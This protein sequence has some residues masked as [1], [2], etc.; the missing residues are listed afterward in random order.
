MRPACV[1]IL[2][3][4]V[5]SIASEPSP[6]LSEAVREAVAARRLRDSIL[7]GRETV[8]SP[9]RVSERD[10]GVLIGLEVGLG[11]N[12]H[13]E[14]VRCLR[15]IYRAGDRH[16]MGPPV[17]DFVAPEVTRTI[18]A[19]ARD[20]YVV[21]GVLVSAGPGIDGISLRYYRPSNSWLDP[22]N[23]YQSE[24]LGTC[25]A[26]AAELVDGQRRPVVGLFGRI[27]GGAIQA[28]GVTIADVVVP[29][30]PVS[31]PAPPARPPVGMSRLEADAPVKPATTNSGSGT[32]AVWMSMAA[33]ILGGCIAV[34]WYR[35]RIRLRREA[36][37]RLRPQAVRPPLQLP[38]MVG[39]VRPPLAGATA[40]TARPLTSFSIP[41]G[42]PAGTIV[43]PFRR[44][45]P[46][47]P[48]N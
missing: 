41:T 14:R 39:P 37:P 20:G 25:A 45:T 38:P 10:G 42:A 40:R 4:S 3:A 12:A 18:R 43:S 46:T 15:P 23:Q 16:W 27:D 21:G 48:P 24:W 30:T 6:G 36:D 35:R 22:D 5:P 33:A 9:F 1:L 32:W 28:F 34:L 47:V 19:V 44:T 8:G 2:A 17:G 31:P 7:Q 11:R 26:G 13:G 29:P